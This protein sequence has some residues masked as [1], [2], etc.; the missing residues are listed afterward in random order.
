VQNNSLSVRFERRMKLIMTGYTRTFHL[1]SATT[2]VINVGDIR[3]KL[4]KTLNVPES[5]WRPRYGDIFEQDFTFPSQCVHI[6]LPGASLLVDAGDFALSFPPGSP[7]FQPGYQPPPGLIDQL[8]EQGIHPGDITHL[9]ITHAHFDHYSAV[10]TQRERHYVPTFP[11]ARCF[12]GRADWENSGTQQALQDPDSE[13]SHTLGVLHRLG[14]L[15]VVEGSRD[16]FPAVRIIA[17]PGE[18]PGHQIVRVYSEGQTLYCL[19]DLYHHA[20]EVEQPTWM[21]GW[22]NREANIAS[23]HALAEA[24]LAENALLVAAHMPVG[25][26]ERTGSGARWV[27]V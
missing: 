24:A 18:S 25:R 7:Y 3:L 8:R 22:A 21:A 6:A 12:L 4:A 17:A 20:V 9:I 11:N 15:E 27:N 5:E 13:D 26:L 23:R 16:L 19:G 10:T 1:G 14:L 2:S